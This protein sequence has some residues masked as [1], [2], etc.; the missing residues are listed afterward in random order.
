MRNRKREITGHNFEFDE[1][2]H[3]LEGDFFHLLRVISNPFLGLDQRSQACQII[4]KNSSR[5]GEQR[6]PILDSKKI[7]LGK[8]KPFSSFWDCGCTFGCIFIVSGRAGLNHEK[9]YFPGFPIK[10]GKNEYPF[11]RNNQQ[12]SKKNLCYSVFLPRGSR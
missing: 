11:L 10:L 3:Q 12:R 1:R 9:A 2:K 6:N 8:K 5:K 4:L 7:V